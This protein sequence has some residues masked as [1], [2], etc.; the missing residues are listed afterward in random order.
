M[1][2][3]SVIRYK[4]LDGAV[5]YLMPNESCGISLSAIASK[6][7]PKGATWEIIAAD[8]DEFVAFIKA[9]QV[10]NERLRR[11]ETEVDAIAINAIRWASLTD[12]QRQAW[13]DYRQALLDVPQQEGFPHNVVWPVKP[14]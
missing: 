11:L 2:M 7:C 13:A 1:M 10:R 4:S 12:A 9:K 3:A 5:G 14:D 8:S 6:D